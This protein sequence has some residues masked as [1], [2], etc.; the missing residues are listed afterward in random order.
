MET[1]DA[2]SRLVAK[3]FEGPHCSR[4]H[5]ESKFH[6]DM[7]ALVEHLQKHQVHKL[8]AGREVF[9]TGACLSRGLA[10]KRT[11][12]FDAMA[13]GAEA[14]SRGKWSE[15]LKQTTFD[16]ALGYPVDTPEANDQNEAPVTDTCFDK[17]KNPLSY[18]SDEAVQGHL[19]GQGGCTGVGGIGGGDDMYC[20][21]QL[22]GGGGG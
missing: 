6:T 17:S 10:A 5:K 8:T 21:D 22:G 12:V 13:L 7:R 19:D 11:G 4:R 18:S 9:G 20:G 16:P 3:F 2:L 1:L 15:Y 14:L